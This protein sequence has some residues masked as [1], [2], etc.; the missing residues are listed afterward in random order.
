MLF[1]NVLRLQRGEAIVSSLYNMADGVRQ[2]DTLIEHMADTEN[3]TDVE[4]E[5]EDLGQMMSMF[6][7]VRKL[8][9]SSLYSKV[10][11]NFSEE[12]I[13][14]CILRETASWV[15]SYFNNIT[16]QFIIQ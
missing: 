4:M 3:L 10:V 9:S 5:R 11:L 13:C 7:E 2:Q 12:S 8:T 16:T 6:L 14:F 1:E 15:Y